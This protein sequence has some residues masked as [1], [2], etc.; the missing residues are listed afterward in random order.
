[1]FRGVWKAAAGL[2]YSN[3]GSTRF[4]LV[5]KHSNTCLGQVEGNRRMRQL[6]NTHLDN[7][8]SA[9]W[10]QRISSHALIRNGHCKDAINSKHTITNECAVLNVSY[11]SHKGPVYE[12]KIIPPLSFWPQLQESVWEISFQLPAFISPL[13]V[14]MRNFHLNQVWYHLSTS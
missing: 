2:L 9:F 13:S 8:L 14:P 11:I 4:I 6:D 10:I 7:P 12:I 5:S 3:N 1:M